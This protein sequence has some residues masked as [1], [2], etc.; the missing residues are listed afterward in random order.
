M[1]KNWDID[2][3]KA[4][5]WGLTSRDYTDYR[6]GYSSSFYEI[7][8]AKHLGISGQ[9][10]LDLG[11][12]TGELALNFAQAGSRVTGIDLAENQLEFARKRA[13]EKGL[14]VDF[15][16]AA[17]EEFPLEE[18]CFDLISASMCWIYFDKAILVPRLNM[19]LK[20][21]GKLLIS[22]HIWLPFEDEIAGKTEELV[23][24]YNPGWTGA[25]FKAQEYR[26]PEWTK[27][28]F[29]S[30]D[31]ISFREPVAFTRKSWRGRIRACR[32]V[33]ASLPGEKVNEFDREL[34]LWLKQEKLENFCI[35]HFNS[36]QIYQPSRS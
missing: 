25:G 9:T 24:K 22:S 16:L 26:I 8:K 23:L 7:L 4:F 34:D 30:V 20:P 13:V 35:L 17:A 11:T 33:G 1:I 19:A 18:N 21:D 29:K 15:H 3:G 12:G 5:D 6:P 10:V 27:G 28:Y 14:A 31:Y 32:G 2:G 36:I